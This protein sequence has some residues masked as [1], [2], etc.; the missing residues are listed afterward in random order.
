MKNRKLPMIGYCFFGLFF[1]TGIFALATASQDAQGYTADDCI[2]CHSSGSGESFLQISIENF[3]DSVHG[4]SVTCL[5]CHTGITGE[6]HMSGEGVARVNC[7]GCHEMETGKT[8]LFSIFSSSRIAS[9]KKANF[10]TNYKM[11][12]CL[13][14]HQGT[15]AHGETEPINE[16]DCYKCHDPNLKAAMWGY[17]HPET[18]DKTVAV[19][20]MQTCFSIFI[21][22]ALFG[23]FLMP[24]F[25][26]FLGKNNKS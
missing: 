11:D 7:S 18:K 19:I 24:V 10:S 16:Q 4:R 15:G 2:E 20:L 23:R 13:G 1:L 26:D 21:L 12:N 14:C 3:D 5:E 17:M 8:G 9:H 6:D 25:N 22:V